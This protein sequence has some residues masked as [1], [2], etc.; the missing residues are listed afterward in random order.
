M[1]DLW[2]C[3]FCVPGLLLFSP[4]WTGQGGVM[5]RFRYKGSEKMGIR[6]DVEPTVDAVVFYRRLE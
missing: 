2:E 6:R 3:G 4:A 1:R 5:F